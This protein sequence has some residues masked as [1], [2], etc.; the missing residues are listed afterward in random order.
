MVEAP[1]RRYLAAMSEDAAPDP[2]LSRLSA[3]LGSL[4]KRGLPPVETLEPALLRR[5]RH[6]HRRRRDVAP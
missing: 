3:A 6:P 2:A 4:P 5:D 1:A